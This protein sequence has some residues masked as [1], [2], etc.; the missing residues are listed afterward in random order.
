MKKIII[1]KRY[2]ECIGPGEIISIIDELPQSLFPTIRDLVVKRNAELAER[3]EWPIYYVVEIVNVESTVPSELILPLDPFESSVNPIE[4]ANLQDIK[5]VLA[6][7]NYVMAIKLRRQHTNCSLRDAKDYID[8]L[9]LQIDD[10]R[11]N[12]KSSG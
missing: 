5:N 1:Y 10:E 9:I 2:P 4:A 7:N 3:S 12:E 11:K 8:M 6:D